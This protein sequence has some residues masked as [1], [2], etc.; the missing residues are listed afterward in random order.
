MEK[1]IVGDG[2]YDI[3]WQRS[4]LKN[5]V[6]NP[7]G[8][9]VMSDEDYFYSLA[10]HA[11]YQKKAGLSEEYRERLAEMRPECKDYQQANYIKA[12]HEYMLRHGYFYTH[13]V[14]D[15]VVRC[16]DRTP[17]RSYV[18]TVSLYSEIV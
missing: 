14:D 1:S 15:S 6:R 12:L 17:D 2:Y 18:K 10:Y 16:F 5:R 8:F 3:N 7:L 4:M 13:T 9:Y 11:I